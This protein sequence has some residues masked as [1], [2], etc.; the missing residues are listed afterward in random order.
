LGFAATVFLLAARQGPCF[1]FHQPLRCEGVG[2]AVLLAINVLD[3]E[4]IEGLGHFLGALEERSQVFRSSLC[5][6]AASA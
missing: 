1:L 4:R 2:F 6:V 3:A 5:T